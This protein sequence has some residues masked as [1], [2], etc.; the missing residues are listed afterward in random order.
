MQEDFLSSYNLKEKNFI[1]A[2]VE[3]YEDKE[4]IFFF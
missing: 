2:P 3:G 1:T 4:T